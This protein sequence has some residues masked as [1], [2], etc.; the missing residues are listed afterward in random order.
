MEEK[1]KNKSKKETVARYA[2]PISFIIELCQSL[3]IHVWYWPK[4]QATLSRRRHVVEDIRINRSFFKAV[5]WIV[6]SCSLLWY[7]FTKGIAWLHCAHTQKRLVKVTSVTFDQSCKTEEEW[8]WSI[9]V[10]D[11]TNALCKNARKLNSRPARDL[12]SS[13][14]KKKNEKKNNMLLRTSLAKNDQINTVSHAIM[15]IYVQTRLSLKWRDN[16]ASLSMELLHRTWR[17]LKRKASSD[18]SLFLVHSNFLLYY[19][20]RRFVVSTKNFP[21]FS[22]S[23]SFALIIYI[24]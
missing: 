21:M 2:L 22:L 14:Q 24:S 7:E 13:E 15:C 3:V 5:S 10:R 12:L 8:A 6:R 18:L 16:D 20:T 17:S 1:K 9:L 19:T 4:V 11:V 23:L